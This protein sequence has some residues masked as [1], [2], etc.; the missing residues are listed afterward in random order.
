MS[1]T[2]FVLFGGSGYIGQHLAVHLLNNGHEVVILDQ[3]PPTVESLRPCYQS[4]GRD[5]L[6]RADARFVHLAC[7]RNNR[8]CWD[9][10]RAE[11]ALDE[12]LSLAGRTRG[13]KLFVSSLSVF[14]HPDNEYARFKRMAER[15]VSGWQIARLGTV[16]GAI[17][18]CGYRADLGLHQIARDIAPWCSSTVQRH[19]IPIGRVVEGI[20][21]QLINP[22]SFWLQ[23]YTMGLA[24]FADIV[25]PGIELRPGPAPEY[26]AS[27]GSRVL[28]EG[29]R[30]LRRTFNQ[31]VDDM[32]AGRVHAC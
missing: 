4:L 7:P 25:P 29:L 28:G 32:R 16:L 8:A 14:D 26:I 20:Y 30:E 6:F 27:E 18:P 23:C 31:L 11:C 12:G 22:S 13:N 17:P 3:V 5:V 10:K 24:R 21:Q 9:W 1:A 15:A 19:V 2:Q